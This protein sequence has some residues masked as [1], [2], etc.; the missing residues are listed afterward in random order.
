MTRVQPLFE[1]GSED[2]IEHI[3]RDIVSKWKSRPSD[4]HNVEMVIQFLVSKVA[5]F[6]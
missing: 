3:A 4:D 1:L 5:V 6:S 2:V